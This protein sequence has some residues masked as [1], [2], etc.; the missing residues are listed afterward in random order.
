MKK[1]QGYTNLYK[2]DETGV[3]TNRAGSERQRYRIAK[4]NAYRSIQQGDEIELLKNDVAHNYKNITTGKFRQIS[5]NNFFEEVINA[6][7]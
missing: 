6:C 3:I 7:S 1:V 4:E 2:D 5:N